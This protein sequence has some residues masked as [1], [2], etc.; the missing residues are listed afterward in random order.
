MKRTWAVAT[1][2]VSLGSVARLTQADQALP[3]KPPSQTVS[4]VYESDQQKVLEQFL[5]DGPFA[6]TV[7]Q[8]DQDLLQDLED[9]K[10]KK[11]HIRSMQTPRKDS[12]LDPN[13]R[14]NTVGINLGGQHLGTESKTQNPVLQ[15]LT[16]PL[17]TAQPTRFLKIEA[18]AS[19]IPVAARL[20]PVQS[21]VTP[22][23]TDAKRDSIQAAH[24]SNLS[25][26]PQRRARVSPS[27][28]SVLA[29]T[30]NQNIPGSS[31]SAHGKRYLS[32]SRERAAT[33]NHS[34][35]VKSSKIKRSRATTSENHSRL[36]EKHRRL[37][38]N[39]IT[40]IASRRHSTSDLTNRTSE[41]PASEVNHP[42]VIAAASA[43]DSAGAAHNHTLE[44][45]MKNPN[46]DRMIML[47]ILGLIT[48]MSGSL[49]IRHL[50]GTPKHQPNE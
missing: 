38:S 9:K 23:Q 35:Q 19:K 8:S 28:R 25:I 37:Q 5:N 36:N 33:A 34:H 12:V 22:Y 13:I 43:P 47:M 40:T 45:S 48:A 2:S 44:A 50:R 17:A 29:T 4:S 24:R 41:D 30:Q 11:K 20:T 31:S 49:L 32:L 10:S 21:T 18:K 39:S 3:T 27:M 7:S 15:G 26:A 14:R 6:A 46:S 16:K 42:I 1:L